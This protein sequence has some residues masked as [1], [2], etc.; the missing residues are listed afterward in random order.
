MSPFLFLFCF[1]LEDAFI[2]KTIG[3]GCLPQSEALSYRAT[4]LRYH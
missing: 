2:L 4:I 3:T 1:C